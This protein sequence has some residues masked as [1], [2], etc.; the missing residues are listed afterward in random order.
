MKKKCI[1][2]LT[3]VVL[4][5][6]FLSSAVAEIN[7]SSLTYKELLMLRD[8]LSKELMTRPEWKE[9]TVPAGDWIVGKD[10]PAGVYSIIIPKGGSNNVD[11]LVTSAAGVYVDGTNGNDNN[12][13]TYSYPV[14]T[15]EKALAMSND[16]RIFSGTYL[17]ADGVLNASRRDYRISAVHT[18][19]VALKFGHSIAVTKNNSTGFY[20]SGTISFDATTYQNYPLYND[21]VPDPATEILAEEI[22]PAQ[23]GHV[24][25]LESTRY[26][27]YESASDLANVT[28][29]YYYD[30]TKFVIKSDQT[31]TELWMPSFSYINLAYS[32]NEFVGVDVLYSSI[33]VEKG[34][35]NMTDCRVLFPSSPI[36]GGV[37]YYASRLNFLRVEVA[38]EECSNSENSENTGDGICGLSMHKDYMRNELTA[39]LI[40]CWLHDSQDDGFS[41][42]GQGSNTVIGGLFEYNRK[43]GAMPASGVNTLMIGVTARHQR[44]G[45]SSVNSMMYGNA[46]DA[47]MGMWLIDCI[48]EN[49]EYNFSIQ[50][51][52]ST[53]VCQNC[54]SRNASEVGY[55]KT[56]GA[57]TSKFVL[58]NCYSDGDTTIKSDGVSVRNGTL[59]Q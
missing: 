21:G 29:G 11:R 41:D 13:G 26:R 32:F 27:Q 44:H 12:A 57:S 56:S 40:D 19:K 48:C 46:D 58:Y 7:L 37:C 47:W 20:E 8:Q 50:N 28:R 4:L 25:R 53:V 59:V 34:D 22:H 49:N 38:G 1:L 42:H 23:Q 2:I 55:Y 35:L 3:I 16:I 17:L 14:K 51:G 52:F 33:Q 54:V 39:T 10:I 5:S 31:L 45:L 24:Y 6:I 9:V 43:S 15:I 36:P 18:N 30:G